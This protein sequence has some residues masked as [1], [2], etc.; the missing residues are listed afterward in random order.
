MGNS[1]YYII[2]LT[3]TSK[4]EVNKQSIFIRDGCKPRVEV[5]SESSGAILCSYH[6][7]EDLGIKLYV[8]HLDLR[9]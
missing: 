4:Y 1:C 5:G 7:Q 3:A 2:M 6:C 8:N 9:R